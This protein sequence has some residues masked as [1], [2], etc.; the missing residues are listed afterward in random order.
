VGSSGENTSFLNIASSN[1]NSAASS[2][3]NN[4]HHDGNGASVAASVSSLNSK[5][6]RFSFKPEHLVVRNFEFCV[7]D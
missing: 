2:F 6:T 5:R 7:H 3:I 4:F 1:A